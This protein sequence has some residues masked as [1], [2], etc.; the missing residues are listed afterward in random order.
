MLIIA[1]VILNWNGKKDTLECLESIKQLSVLS[2]HLSVVVVDNGSTDGSQEAI[3]REF[4]EVV[5][6]ENKKNLGFA[7]GNNVGIKYALENGAD[8]VMLLNNDTLVDKNLVSELVKVMEK[9]KTIGMVGPKIYFASG[10]EFHKERYSRQDLGK[11]IW[12]A[13]GVI[14][15]QN[16]YASHRGVDEVDR[17]QYD[18]VAETDFTSG[19]AMMIRKEVFQKIGL[20]DPQYFLYWEDTDLCQRAREAGFKIFYVPQAFLWHK[21]AASSEKPGSE[22]H[23]YYQT[24]NRLLFG[25]E[26]GNLR[27]KFALFRESM[28]FLMAGGI[29]QQA[30]LD[31]YLG[32]FAKGE[33]HSIAS[34]Q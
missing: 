24:R 28:K 9:D 17:R 5:S 16:V 14:D 3:K 22:L 30:V 32:K 25:M 2:C 26:Y 4:S 21:N 15:W 19:C 23:Q 29:R 20:F 10:F 34:K 31:F 12:Y 7:Q 33:I 8:Y 6:I 27:A 1:I 18:G 11:V 13:G